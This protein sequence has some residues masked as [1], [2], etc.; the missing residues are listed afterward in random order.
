MA[1][2]GSCLVVTW[3]TFKIHFLKVDLTQNQETMALRNLITVDLFYSIIC[4]DPA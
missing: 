3:F 2:N 1:S 4:E